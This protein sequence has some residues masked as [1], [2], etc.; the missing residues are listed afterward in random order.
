[1][2][3]NRN[4]GSKDTGQA[5]PGHGQGLVGAADVIHEGQAALAG[6]GGVGLQGKSRAQSSQ[7]HVLPPEHTKSK[8][9]APSSS[10][11]CP[12]PS[13]KQS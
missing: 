1:M 8:G 11:A 5:V 4:A 3:A 2:P 13:I 7:H 9:S 10:S 12:S 6:A